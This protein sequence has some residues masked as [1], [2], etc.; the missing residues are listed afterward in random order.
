M[1]YYIIQTSI[2]IIGYEIVD[3]FVTAIDFN[4]TKKAN[5]NFTTLSHKVENEIINYLSSKSKALDIPIKLNVTPFQTKVLESM[6]KIPYGQTMSYQA[7][8]ESIGIPKGS[9][10]VGNACGA[11]PLPLYYPCHR[12]IKSDGGL[13]GFSGGLSI[14]KQ[15]LSL[16][17]MSHETR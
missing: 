12:V 4:P 3:D 1:S 16:E 6:K 8:A 7:L 15:L 13:G 9:R 5:G 2:G 17:S 10:A 11:N 14:K